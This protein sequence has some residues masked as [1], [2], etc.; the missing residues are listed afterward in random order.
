MD[1]NGIGSKGTKGY[2]YIDIPNSVNRRYD[3]N[4]RIYWYDANNLLRIY[5]CLTSDLPID[6]RSTTSKFNRE[7]KDIFGFTGRHICVVNQLKSSK[8]KYL[9]DV[10][11]WCYSPKPS[12][13]QIDKSI[14]VLREPDCY[15]VEEFEDIKRE[16]FNDQQKKKN[17]YRR[18]VNNL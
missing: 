3:C 12:D 18:F 14:A 11:F 2:Y 9:Y 10:D 13:D 6:T 5:I 16:E 4:S 7:L 17:R 15:T 1:W 8:G